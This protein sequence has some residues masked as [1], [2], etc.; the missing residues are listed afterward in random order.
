MYLHTSHKYR[1]ISTFQ[2]RESTLYYVTYLMVRFALYSYLMHGRL[3]PILMQVYS[4]K[5]ELISIEG[6]WSGKP[7]CVLTMTAEILSLT[8]MNEK[9]LEVV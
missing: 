7:R 9:L 2:Y 8:K 6:N 4:C 3:L 1:P 5:L